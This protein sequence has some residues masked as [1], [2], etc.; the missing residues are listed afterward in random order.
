MPKTRQTLA[1]PRKADTGLSENTTKKKKK[2]SDKCYHSYIKKLISEHGKDL[3]GEKR[4]S[5]SSRAV[6]V[7]DNLLRKFTKDVASNAWIFT[8]NRKSKTVSSDQIHYATRH[9]LR[10]KSRLSIPG[11]SIDVDGNTGSEFADYVCMKGT[12]AL[13]TF[14]ATEKEKKPTKA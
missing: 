5:V 11:L 3:D 9:V 8:K 4:I 2:R 7:L 6:D 1:K 12:E 13:E 10:P 14:R